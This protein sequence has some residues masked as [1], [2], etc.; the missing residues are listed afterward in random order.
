MPEPIEGEGLK[1]VKVFQICDSDSVAAYSLEEAIRWYLEQTGISEDELYT[2]DEI[3]ELNMDLE[4]YEDDGLA[5][6]IK[7]SE[8]LKTYWDG[9]PFIVTTSYY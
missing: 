5:G 2:R 9:S 4:V 8:I 7:I 6:K 3:E 1:G